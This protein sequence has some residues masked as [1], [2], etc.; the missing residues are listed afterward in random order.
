MS[1]TDRFRCVLFLLIPFCL[2]GMGT[3]EEII[4]RVEAHLVIEDL[5]RALEEAEALALAYP[6]SLK[7]SS[8]L[9]QTLAANGFEREALE[10]LERTVALTEDHLLLEAF[11]WGVLNKGVQS[12]Q[13]GVRLAALIGA[14][15]TR[16]ARAIPILVTM[17][18]DSNAV[19]RSIA[20]QLSTSY[21]DFPL[22]EEVARLI[23]EEKVWMVRL[24]AIKALG[25]LRMKAFAPWLKSLVQDDKVTYEEKM[26]AIESLTKIYDNVCW[27]ELKTL[28]ESSRAGLRHL[29]C[30]LAVHFQIPHS[31]SLILPLLRDTHPDVRIAALNALA[32]FYL[33]HFTSIEVQGYLAEPL[34]DPHAAVAITASWILLLVDPLLG[35]SHMARWLNDSLP[36]HRRL[37]AAALAAAGH[38]GVALG[39]KTI[40]ESLDPYVRANLALG[41]IG[42]RCEVPLSADI[43]FDFLTSDKRMWMWD[44]RANPLFKALAPSQARYIDQIPNYPEALDQMT[45]LNLVSL[46][47][48]VEDPRAEAALKTFLQRKSWGITG[49]AAA[50]LLQEGDETALELVRSLI[51]DKER[52]VSLQA[53]LVLALFGKDETVLP[54]LHAAYL[55]AGHEQKL[56]ILEALGHVGGKENIPFLLR[57]LRE[58]FPILRVATA[59][60]LIQSLN[61]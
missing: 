51:H 38:R 31:E 55:Q 29:A 9:V 11:A 46:L 30:S 41:L 33:D 34:R 44:S 53:C 8:L 49:V 4:R 17:M 32:L 45:R 25:A 61:R 58:P 16:D 50:T 21:G 28:T 14:Y 10:L 52:N 42:Q 39:L 23:Q 54:D 60:A 20:L 57:T 3:E 36:E 26:L 35:E 47:A 18:R 2:Q 56:H 12:T 24:E 43:L 22:K 40:Q 37:A 13:Y 1:G 7:A 15:L 48:I 5:P 19:I 6:S 59:A 27:D